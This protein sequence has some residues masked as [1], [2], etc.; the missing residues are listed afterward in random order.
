MPDQPQTAMRNRVRA[1]LLIVLVLASGGCDASDG[2]PT[3]TDNTSRDDGGTTSET[4]TL[5]VGQSVK[6]AF[7]QQFDGPPIPIELTLAEVNY[8]DA[9]RAPE[10]R[11][12][13]RPDRGKV[14]VEMRGTVRGIANQK[15]S[16]GSLGL[17]V[18]WL[19]EDG[20]K[21]EAALQP[22]LRDAGEDLTG[23]V[24]PGQYI[25][26]SMWSEVPD[27]PGSLVLDDGTVTIPLRPST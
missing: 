25:K 1:V 16:L 22:L 14:F 4:T 15:S 18:Y 26:G 27:E 13:F 23:N 24:A 19:S 10:C 9:V 21:V 20:R 2:G 12:T 6:F 8:H 3:R 17:S 5:E 11:H 7:I